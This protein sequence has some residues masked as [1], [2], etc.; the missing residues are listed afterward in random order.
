MQ[1]FR[2]II[3]HGSLLHKPTRVKLVFKND[4]I[5][6]TFSIPDNVTFEEA[7][8]TEPLGVALR[9]CR[10]SNITKG[11]KVLITGA[12]ELLLHQYFKLHF[13]YILSI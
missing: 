13:Y 12:G 11:S 2:L 5:I 9:A 3:L 1:K 6:N 7:A 8:V 10:K 4:H